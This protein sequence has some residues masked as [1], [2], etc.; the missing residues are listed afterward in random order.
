MK[1]KLANFINNN[2]KRLNSFTRFKITHI[3][4]QNTKRVH[5]NIHYK[6]DFIIECDRRLSICTR[7][8]VK[9]TMYRVLLDR[10]VCMKL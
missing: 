7:I 4:V 3:C 9:Q 10:I 1:K 5:T 2:N 6:C 8:Y